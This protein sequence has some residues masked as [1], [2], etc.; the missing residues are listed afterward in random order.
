[1]VRGGIRTGIEEIVESGTAYRQPGSGRKLIVHSPE[2]RVHPSR[3][4]H[5]DVKS[6]IWAVVCV[7]VRLMCVS[8]TAEEM[9]PILDDRTAKG[10]AQLLIRIRED[11]L[12]DKIR[13]VE[14]VVTEIAPERAGEGIRSRLG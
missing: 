8:V 10:C 13:S 7:G 3:Q 9:Y 5:V 14:L 12:G 2:H 4:V 11:A 1:M 6:R